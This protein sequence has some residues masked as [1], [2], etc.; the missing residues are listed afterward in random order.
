VDRFRF[1][2]LLAPLAYDGEQHASSNNTTI[3]IGS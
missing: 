1:A 3:G 2:A